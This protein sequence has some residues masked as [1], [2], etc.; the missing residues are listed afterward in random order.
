MSRGICRERIVSPQER[1]KKCI[2]K[3]HPTRQDL[4]NH[5][6]KAIAASKHC[7]DDQESLRQKVKEC[8]ASG[9]GKFL[10]WINCTR[11]VC[12]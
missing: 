11:G 1:P 8:Q 3:Y 5:I 4:R 2:R 10:Y 6:T 7:K 9:T 12:S